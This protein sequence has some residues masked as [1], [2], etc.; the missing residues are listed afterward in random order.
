MP[1]IIT[2]ALCAKDILQRLPESQLTHA[3]N[4][5][6]RLY[7][8]ASSGP[9]FLFYYKAYPLQDAKAAAHIHQIGDMVHRERINA[10]YIRAVDLIRSCPEAALKT[11][12]TS[13]LAGHLTHWALD[14]VAHPFVFYRSGEMK[15]KTQYWHYRFESMLDTLMVKE[16]KKLPL[17]K[18]PSYAFVSLSPND[19]SA[20]AKFYQAI[21]SAVFDRREG[22]EVFDQAFKDMGLISKWLFDPQTRLFPWVQRIERL[23]KQDWKFSSHMVI[24]ESD[25][26][27]DVLNLSHSPWCH[28]SDAHKISTESFVD[29]YHQGVE[30]GV[31]ALQALDAV[32]NH[33]QPIE[34]LTTVLKNQ[35]YDTGLSEFMAMQHYASIYET[36]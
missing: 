33:R 10:F 29:L 18:T 34:Q 7:T 15:G 13:F 27:H 16:V 28:P 8:T 30:R 9:D 3:I 32:L 31:V 22:I 4:Q 23:L 24:G 12:W 5:H 35:S 36:L 21:V 19:R 20:S 1:N 14:S 26:R 2:H 17:S 25:T 6:A 11:Q